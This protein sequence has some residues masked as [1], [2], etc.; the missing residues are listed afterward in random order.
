MNC[1]GWATML[2]RL[3]CVLTVGHWRLVHREP[4]RISLRCVLCGSETPGWEV[5]A[6]TPRAR[7]VAFRR[8]VNTKMARTA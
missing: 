5:A 3:W 2:R 6:T 4:T 1:R 7:V 8:P